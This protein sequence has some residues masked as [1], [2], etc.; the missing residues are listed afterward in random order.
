KMRRKAKMLSSI[1]L[2]AIGVALIAFSVSSSSFTSI[3]NEVNVPANSSFPIKYPSD[4]QVIISLNST[5]PLSVSMLPPGATSENDSIV[6][7]YCFISSSGGEILVH[8]IN[9]ASSTIYYDV[10]Y[11]HSST[12]GKEYSFVAGIVC[13]G[14][15]VLAVIFFLTRR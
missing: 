13:L 7:V 15:G 14:F 8:N 12:V 9:N 6:Y 5:T 1:A 10:Q 3:S 11:A 2:I 4:S